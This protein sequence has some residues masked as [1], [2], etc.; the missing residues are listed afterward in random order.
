M[1]RYAQWAVFPAV[2]LGWLLTAEPAT[3]QKKKTPARTVQDEAGLFSPTAVQKANAEIAEIKRIYNKDLLI[4]TFG[5]ARAGI[6]KVELKDRQAKRQFFVD[7]ALERAKNSLVE[8][9]YVLICK[10]PH[11]VQT[12]VG[13]R[14]RETGT[15]TNK[16]GDV[17]AEKMIADLRVNKP[18]QA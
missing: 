9:V 17:L 7:W 2:L 16:N 10:D 5:K 1:L 8:G 3:A 11:Y 12:V 13:Q 6:E 14:T 18:D 15:F 4:E